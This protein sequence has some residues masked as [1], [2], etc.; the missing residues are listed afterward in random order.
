MNHYQKNNLEF[1]QNL[2]IPCL[3]ASAPISGF[4]AAHLTY[5]NRFPAHPKGAFHRNFPSWPLTRALNHTK[6]HV[7]LPSGQ[8]LCLQDGRQPIF[9]ATSPILLLYGSLAPGNS[10]PLIPYNP[11]IWLM[12]PPNP[13]TTPPNLS[14]KCANST[15][16]NSI[17]PSPI[18]ALFPPAQIFLLSFYEMKS[19]SHN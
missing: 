5:C 8:P 13:G 6:H 19:S 7:H 9:L 3:K 18:L 17:L 16:C 12:L 4:L 2:A 15:P 1:T 14:T 11:E 10:V